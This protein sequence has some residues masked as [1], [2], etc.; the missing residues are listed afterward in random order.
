MERTVQESEKT[1]RLVSRL[2]LLFAFAL[3]A[4]LLFEAPVQ[5]QV[6]AI[7]GKVKAYGARHSGDAVVYIEKIPGKTFSPPSKPVTLDQLKL[8]FIPHVLPV[9]AGTTV[10]FPNSDDVRHNVFSVSRPKR[11]NLGTYPRGVMKYVTFDNPGLVSLLCNVHTEMSAYVVVTET[12]YF[13]VT[14]RDGSYII[15]NVPP[16]R[17]TLKAWHERLRPQ[18]RQIEVV[19]GSPTQADFDLR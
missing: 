18:V 1:L 4:V 9:L 15:K 2:S 12:P 13:A 8:T 11:F 10:V 19:A 7:A 3:L 5:A 14:Q 17:Y 16:G 6:G